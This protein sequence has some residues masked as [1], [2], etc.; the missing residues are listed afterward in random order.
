MYEDNQR[1]RSDL[2]STPGPV[3][4]VVDATARRGPRPEEML[5]FKRQA[6]E[7]ARQAA[8]RKKA[9][10]IAEAYGDWDGFDD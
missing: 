6:A 9:R 3:R 1:W 4:R 2:P 7:A 5:I 10:E 8:E